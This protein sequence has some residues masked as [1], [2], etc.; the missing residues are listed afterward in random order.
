MTLSR[1]TWLVILAVSTGLACGG[2]GGGGPQTTLAVAKA[3]P[4]GDN[5]TDTVLS[6]LA[7]PYRVLV[8]RDGTPA[9]GVTV[10]WSVPAGQGSV[11]PASVATGADGIASV[12]RTLGPTAGTQTA[13]AAVTGATGSPVAFTASATAGNV[14]ALRKTGGDGGTATPGSTVTYTVTAEDGH[15]NPKA[16]VTIDWAVTGGGGSIAPPQNATG[17]GGTAS[18]T[19]TLSGSEGPHTATATA[20]AIPATVTFTTTAVAA[21]ATA[22]VSVGNNFFNPD[23]VTIAQ[24][25]SVTW[26]WNS[27][28]VQHNVTFSG[29]GAPTSCPTVGSGTCARQF[30]NAG[31]F[32]YVCTLHAG[33]DGKVVVVP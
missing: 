33:M 11:S 21:P 3:N 12:T 18:A 26:T 6:T 27:G 24:N 31:T 13:Q 2:D 9:Q 19:R 28:G 10:T 16:G 32:N 5:Q 23:S 15:G 14:A 22:D 8:T 25:G 20:N 17:A 30:S 4:S 1:P 29:A 7:N